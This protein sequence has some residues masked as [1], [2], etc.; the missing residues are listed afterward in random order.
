[1]VTTPGT[2]VVAASIEI[3][4][5]PALA[6]YGF[7][8]GSAP[9]LKCQGKPATVQGGPFRDDLIAGRVTATGAGA[10]LIRE[11]QGTICAGAGADR[12][13]GEPYLGTARGKVLLGDGS[14]MVMSK[15]RIAGPVF[16][17][18]GADGIYG[19]EGISGGPGADR[20]KGYGRLVGGPG[21]DR[22]AGS[23]END[24][25]FGG[26]GRDKIV[27]GDLDDLLVGGPGRD[28]LIGGRGTDRLYGGPGLDGMRPGPTGPRYRTYSG[29]VGATHFEARI[30]KHRIYDGFVG[31]RV[32]CNNGDTYRT[33]LS[34]YR[35][36]LMEGDD[37]FVAESD[38]DTGDE[39]L[40]GSFK[41]IGDIT[42]GVI[43]GRFRAREWVSSVYYEDRNCLSGKPGNPWVRF[44]A[45]RKPDPVQISRQ[46]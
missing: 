45:E 19:G 37:R 21:N 17:G 42:P 44:R 32:H 15:T 38:Y 31:T 18:E 24:S 16:G 46:D 43:E 27:G 39:G 12:L 40:Y 5:S 20:I 10:D 13:T 26:P 33:D 3:D 23:D 1:V 34:F 41:A 36:K 7:D 9:R 4:E 6:L 35:D 30:Y 25:I 8:N 28:D 2:I 14:D 22:I 29:T 11:P